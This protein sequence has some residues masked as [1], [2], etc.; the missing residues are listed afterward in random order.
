MKKLITV[1]TFC[2]L[3]TNMYSQKSFNS[4]SFSKFLTTTGSPSILDYGVFAKKDAAN[5]LKVTETIKSGT[6][7]INTTDLSVVVKTEGGADMI[8]K[9][10]SIYNEEKEKNHDKTLKI[11][12]SDV[13]GIQYLLTIIRNDAF[14]KINQMNVQ[15]LQDNGDGYKYTC[16]YLKD[17]F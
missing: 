2:V 7:N 6:I 15:I 11:P 4:I 8:Y 14:K 5:N 16:S 3:V 17:L 1:V 12:C 9:I 10:L 13:R